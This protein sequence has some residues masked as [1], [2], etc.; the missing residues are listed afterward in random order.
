GC[1]R[2]SGV[3]SRWPSTPWPSTCWGSPGR[4]DRRRGQA[5]RGRVAMPL[6]LISLDTRFD[7]PDAAT[8]AHVLG[9]LDGGRN[10]LATP[11]PG[12]SHYPQAEGH[13]HTGFAP[14]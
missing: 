14:H 3:P 8:I 5:R 1:R 7:D 9:S 10:V 2:S 12:E 6:T 11:Q 4:T 13:G